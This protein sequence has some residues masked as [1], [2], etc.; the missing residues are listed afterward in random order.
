MFSTTTIASSTTKPTAMVMAISERLSR[1]K[2]S[3]YITAVAPAS[4][5]GTTTAGIKVA[6]T[7]RR[8]KRMTSTTSAIVRANVNSTSATEARIVC[9]R[10]T[11]VSIFIPGG[12]SAASR[13][14]AAFT[15][16]TVWI[17]FAPGCLNTSRIT[18]LRGP[19]LSPFSAA[20]LRSCGPETAWPTSRTRTGAPL[21]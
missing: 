8:N 20:M 11:M 9:V 1:L 14:I 21:R 12:I 6:R 19:S 2:P 15:S 10:S 13:G 16:S 18:A 17:T 7:L 4:E 5:S 3:T